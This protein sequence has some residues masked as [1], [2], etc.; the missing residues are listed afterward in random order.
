[1]GIPCARAVGPGKACRDDVKRVAA[2]VPLRHSKHVCGSQCHD[3]ARLIPPGRWQIRQV[4]VEVLASGQAFMRCPLRAQ[5]AN[6]GSDRGIAR[7]R[8]DRIRCMKRLQCS[9]AILN[10]HFFIG[11]SAAVRP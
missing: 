11:E 2:V 9:I 7:A 10:G 5:C 1:M 3:M 4:V 8:C 6:Q